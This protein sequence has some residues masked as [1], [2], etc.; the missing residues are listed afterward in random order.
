[1]V[2]TPQ[3]VAFLDVRKAVNAFDLLNIPTLGLVENMV[4]FPFGNSRGEQFAQR[5]QVSYLGSIPVEPKICE[6]TDLGVPFAFNAS[7]QK[8]FALLADNLFHRYCEK[9]TGG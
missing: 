1:M 7:N 4:G 2:T 9:K 3:E 5:L 8:L 6:S